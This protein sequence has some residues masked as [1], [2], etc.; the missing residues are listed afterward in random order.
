MPRRRFAVS[1]P[2][3]LLFAVALLVRPVPA[4]AQLWTRTPYFNGGNWTTCV[5][6]PQ[7]MGGAYVIHEGG[8]L[9]RMYCSNGDRVSYDLRPAGVDA[10]TTIL[11]QAGGLAYA[12]GMTVDA[13]GSYYPAIYVT[14]DYG[15][16]LQLEFVGNLVWPPDPSLPLQFGSI[17]D[18]NPTSVRVPLRMMCSLGSSG[19][20]ASD[21]TVA[22][23][24]QSGGAPNRT[25]WQFP[26]DSMFVVPTPDGG[27]AVGPDGAMF[28][29]PDGGLTWPAAGARLFNVVV[30]DV[31]RSDA[32]TLLIAADGG[33]FYSPDD[34]ASW[35]FNP[36]GGPGTSTTELATSGGTFFAAVRGQ[37]GTTSIASSSEAD[38]AS[39]WT[40]ASSAL[41][42]RV[43]RLA[44]V[45]TT[46]LYAQCGSWLF[47]SV[48]AG[49]SWTSILSL[50]GTFAVDARG[51]IWA[52]RLSYPSYMVMSADG[53]GSWTAMDSGIDG[54]ITSLVI[55][56]SQQMYAGGY[57]G[58]YHS[59][60]PLLVT[61]PAQPSRF[62]V[63]LASG[64]GGADAHRRGGSFDRPCRT[65]GDR[66]WYLERDFGATARAG[67]VLRSRRAGRPRCHDAGGSAGLMPWALF[68]S[69]L[70][71]GARHPHPEHSGGTEVRF[72]RRPARR[73]G[74]SRSDAGS[75]KRGWESCANPSGK[76]HRTSTI[77]G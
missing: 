76:N 24:M 2:C 12:G 44:A 33:V 75:V 45:S 51:H 9:F 67:S 36:L 48:D 62:A 60:Q 20:L 11:P 28:R 23:T 65:R 53:G 57:L 32:G 74:R 26:A 59:T 16:T 71:R 52:G 47:R 69:R 39:P 70:T 25:S 29:S 8:A 3:A 66:G 10:M 61:A 22:Y 40:T 41:I 49:G 27:F 6:I 37:S 34:G 42:G 64:P 63:A 77:R 54:P 1:F 72:V 13:G 50:V 56:P 31:A 15:D 35:N 17:H 30:H 7:P 18:A 14:N 58:S 38:L 5:A 21:G 46:E 19:V 73:G 55:S 4:S 68:A 43:N